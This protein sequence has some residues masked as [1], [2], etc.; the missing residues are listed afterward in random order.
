MSCPFYI[1]IQSLII[2]VV[3][4]NQFIDDG[5]LTDKSSLIHL[6]DRHDA[7]DCDEIPLL[8]HSPFYNNNIDLKSNI[9]CI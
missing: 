3:K 7:D 9:Q 1:K 5:N 6:L 2:M 4:C 8:N